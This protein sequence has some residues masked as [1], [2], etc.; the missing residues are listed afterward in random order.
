MLDSKCPAAHQNSRVSAAV[1]FLAILPAA[2]RLRRMT[3]KPQVNSFQFLVCL[4]IAHLTSDS[5]GSATQP[6]P[7][8]FSE[9]SSRGA[10]QAR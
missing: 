2:S 3:V 5:S 1:L 6:G 9:G 8:V 4:L 7:I 10:I